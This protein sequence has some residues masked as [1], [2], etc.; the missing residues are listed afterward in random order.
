MF[1]RFATDFHHIEAELGKYESEEVQAVIKSRQTLLIE[2]MKPNSLVLEEAMTRL[3][4]VMHTYDLEVPRVAHGVFLNISTG[5]NLTRR[6]CVAISEYGSKSGYHALAVEWVQFAQELK[7]ET[8]RQEED[9]METLVERV[10]LQV[11]NYF[12]LLSSKPSETIS[13]ILLRTIMNTV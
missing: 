3:L 5:F 12:E 13:A 10:V 6:H 9:E 4:V 2:E 7:E 11:M 8:T 1:F